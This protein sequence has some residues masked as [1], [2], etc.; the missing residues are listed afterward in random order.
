MA[1]KGKEMESM[2]YI[3]TT[4]KWRFGKLGILGTGIALALGASA[5]LGS[6]DAPIPSVQV[7]ERT[8]AR[9]EPTNVSTTSFRPVRP[10]LVTLKRLSAVHDKEVFPYVE[11]LDDEYTT[12][13]RVKTEA[14]K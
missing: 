10:D 9:I 11:T 3:S 13:L 14:A 5:C 12:T 6:A 2:S 1:T 4:D 7:G 8:Q